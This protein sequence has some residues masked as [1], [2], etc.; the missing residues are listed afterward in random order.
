MIN[1]NM[2]ITMIIYP[3]TMKYGFMYGIHVLVL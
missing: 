3:I 2:M 1:T